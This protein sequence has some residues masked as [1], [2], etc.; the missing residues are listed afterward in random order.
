MVFR[1]S[2][3][4]G[5]KQ[6]KMTKTIGFIGLGIMGEAMS[7]NL[8]KKS[9]CQIIVYDIV[10][11]KIEE[12]AKIG[13]KKAQSIKQLSADSDIIITMVP[14]SEQ[15]MQVY[16]EIIKSMRKN[17]LCINMS[18][19]DPD[20]HLEIVKLVEQKQGN[21][22]DAPV[23]KSKAAAIAGKLG[24]YVGGRKEH[25]AEALPILSCMG[26]QIKYM[27]SHGKGLYMKICHNMLVA[28]IQ[29]G[30]N[31]MLVMAKKADLDIEEVIPA[32]SMGGGQNAYLDT[33]SDA[34]LNE[35]YD[36]AFSIQ[37]MHKDIH[38][39]KRI[40]QNN[41]LILPALDNSIKIYDQAIKKYASFDFSITYKV[42]KENN[43]L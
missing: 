42:V 28:S 37:N 17:T 32:I 23:V 39:A 10:S 4:H 3:E 33:K 2:V 14:A 29:N 27:G 7:T 11:E 26:E 34:I 38:I 8:I 24:I 13:A 21:I 20:T 18:T 25:F 41:G 30:V 36:P 35:K 15:A 19:I 43:D 9:G 6:N 1:N 40:A 16:N 31:E 22:L 12:L 5:R